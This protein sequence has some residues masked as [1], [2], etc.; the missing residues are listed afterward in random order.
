MKK[1]IYSF[2]PW[3]MLACLACGQQVISL[4]PEYDYLHKAL[5]S[6]SY[7]K[8]QTWYGYGYIDSLST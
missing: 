3:L 1:I 8:V 5:Q 6:S 2:V 7:A 4:K